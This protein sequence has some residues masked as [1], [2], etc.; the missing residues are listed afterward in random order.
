M[1]PGLTSALLG[2]GA[3]L[4]TYGVDFNTISLLKFDEHNAAGSIN[5]GD[6]M[7]DYA[8]PSRHW[9]ANA[10]AG[11]YAVSPFAGAAGLYLNGAGAILGP[12]GDT[13]YDLQG[14]FTLDFWVAAGNLSATTG[15]I[16]RSPGAFCPWLV[17]QNAGSLTFYASSNGTSWDIASGL[18]IAS[19]AASY[20][21]YAIQR[22]GNTLTGWLNGSL[23]NTH[24]I[25]GSWPTSAGTPV[26]NWAQAPWSGYID[27]VRFSNIARYTTAFQ[28]PSSPYYRT[29]NGRNDEATKMLLHMDGANGG[30]TFTD[31]AVGANVSG[32][33]IT[34]QASAQTVNSIVKLGNASLSVAIGSLDRLEIAASQDLFLGLQGDFTL[35]FW[36]YPATS[37]SGSVIS[38]R[39]NGSQYAP[40]AISN[41]G[42]GA[43]QLYMSV[44][45]T[46]WDILGAPIGT[47]PVGAW[48][49]VALEG[50]R[51]NTTL[52]SF[53]NGNPVYSNNALTA[54]WYY[55]NQNL[56]IGALSDFAVGPGY[57]DEVRWSN[58]ARYQSQPFT[59]PIAPY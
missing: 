16:A 51:Q 32:R 49:H 31:S 39:A 57:I 9:A 59:P 43:L 20:N 36:Y 28:K 37:G 18:N 40:L 55:P 4:V 15:I 56:C 26:L 30:T 10:A 35:D 21:H 25:S 54:Q 58:V 45:G 5:S 33:V 44:A 1:L 22:K 41:V 46:T 23:Q 27:E 2:R 8:K 7:V 24:T 13:D 14:D 42:S 17:F 52:K 19:L 38:W 48:T 29:L 53:I 11:S 12:A 47:A 6:Q 34:P 50:N 3:P